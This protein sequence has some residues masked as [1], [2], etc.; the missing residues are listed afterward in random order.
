M[1]VFAADG[2]LVL[3]ADPPGLANGAARLAAYHYRGEPKK[4]TETHVRAGILFIAERCET[5]AQ[6]AALVARAR[7]AKIE[8]TEDGWRVA[9]T[10]D[11][12]RLE[13]ARDR[14]TRQPSLRLVNGAAPRAAVLSVN[15]RDLAAE[16]LGR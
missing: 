4:L 12:L 16:I 5:P 11:G 8:T 6:L 7:R 14:K 13:A 15:G 9:A 10:I 1:R 2:E 3:K